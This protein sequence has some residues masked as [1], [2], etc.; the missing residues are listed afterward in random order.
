MRKHMG[1][2]GIVVRLEYF[3]G[4][5][6]VLHD[7]IELGKGHRGVSCTVQVDQRRPHLMHPESR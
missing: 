3:P 5:D 2:V 6:A 1:L 4:R 7:L